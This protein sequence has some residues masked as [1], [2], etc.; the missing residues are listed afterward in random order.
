[1]DCLFPLVDIDSVC[2]PGCSPAPY[3]GVADRLDELDRGWAPGI[4]FPPEKR[5]EVRPTR[6]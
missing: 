4:G 3:G 5:D 6:A 1:V 2:L